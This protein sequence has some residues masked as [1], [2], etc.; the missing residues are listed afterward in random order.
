MAT[1][2]LDWHEHPPAEWTGGAVTVG[3]FDGVHRGH[4][5]LLASARRWA[6][7]QG[8]PAI[9]VTFD[10]PPFQVLHP[11]TGPPRLPLT[12]LTER[13]ELLEGAG[14]D[15]VIVLRTSPA[16]LALSPEAFFEDVLV[17]QLQVKAV[18][19]GYDYRFGRARAGTNAILR[20]LCEAA[21]VGFEEVPPVTIEG[22]VVS[23]SR[24]RASLEAGDVRTAS[25]LLNRRYRI[26]GRVVTGA[27]RGRTIG[28]PT[29]N[30]GDVA[31]LLPAEGV[32]AVRAIA[33]G[34]TWAAA[35]N[36]GP[37]PTF[38]EHARKIEVHLLDFQ[39]D[40]YDSVL[41]I[42]FVAW[43]RETRP[44]AGAAALVEQLQ[45]DV[46]EARRV[47]EN[48]AKPAAEVPHG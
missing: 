23:S 14:A 2:F 20:S 43:L 39:G 35:A 18:I 6:D 28:F 10:P 34:K 17:R 40:L 32:Y 31:T 5:A 24:V 1:L 8:G 38:G 26:T 36:I 45:R 21:G 4:Q 30:L 47:V 7:Q 19:E 13:A 11:D 22:D 15:R 41:A 48:E 44:F 37:N 16:L 12:T 33:G 29:A 46:A 3:N 27:K 25:T 9:A 42:E